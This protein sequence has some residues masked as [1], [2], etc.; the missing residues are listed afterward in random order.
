MLSNLLL[1][2]NSSADASSHEEVLN[3]LEGWKIHYINSDET[4]FQ[5]LTQQIRREEFFFIVILK[6]VSDATAN[7]LIRLRRAYPLLFIIYYN[8]QLKDQEFSKLYLA[9]VDYCFIGDARQLNLL[10][11][12]QELWQ[13]HW[14][15]IPQDLRNKSDSEPTVR[16]KSIFTLIETK[17]LHNLS[18]IVLA[19]HLNISEN[20]F[21]MEFKKYFGLNFREFKQ[22][23]FFRYESYLLFE[24]KLKPRE[25]FDILN[26][27][28]LSAFSRSFKTRHGTSWQY[29][30]RQKSQNLAQEKL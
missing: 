20:H 29:L 1:L 4:S 22:Q 21:R 12:L 9:G 16:V 8:T 10:K 3:Q 11:K 6:K 23:L 25:V 5:A 18:S 7:S 19:R 24:K 13:N 27:T 28:N 26:Y 15:R 2:H 14:R 17:P 30:M